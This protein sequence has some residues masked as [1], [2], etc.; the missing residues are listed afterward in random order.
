MGTLLTVER[1][2]RSTEDER[3]C[4]GSYARGGT[5]PLPSFVPEGRLFLVL[6]GS[7]RCSLF[8]PSIV[9]QQ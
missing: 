3:F 2:I 1:A 7:N 4:K 5:R 8:Q 9:A 6:L